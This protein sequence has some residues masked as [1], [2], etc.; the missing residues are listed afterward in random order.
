VKALRLAGQLGEYWL[1]RG[2]FTG[3]RW[4]DAARDAAG[5]RAPIDDRARVELARAVLLNVQFQFSASTD[6]ARSTVDLYRRA[7]DEAGLSEA[8]T[9]L[10]RALWQLGQEDEF[11]ACV[12]AALRHA[13][14][15]GHDDLY[16][17]QLFRFAHSLPA[18]ERLAALERGAERLTLVGNH[19]D[20]ALGYSDAAYWALREDRPTEALTLLKRALP[21]AEQAGAPL[22][23]M[24]VSSN[25]GLTNLFVSHF[26]RALAAFRRTLR[27]CLDHALG[28]RAGEGLAGLAALAATQGRPERAARLLGAARAR[29]YPAAD[30]QV[31]LDRLDRDYL[32]P[33]RARSGID[34]WRRE[35][36]AG[37]M[38]S[39][40]EA[41]AYAL[42]RPAAPDQNEDGVKPAARQSAR[43]ETPSHVGGFRHHRVRKQRRGD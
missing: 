18:D 36:Q 29:G 39:Y 33:A 3:L 32:A 30:D 1:V 5:D 34:A 11:R 17:K 4:L 2:D 10:A 12:E 20:L 9:W 28:D 8:Y 21:A 35:E 27:L 40:D 19:R 37:A 14:L 41:I 25:L 38:L 42:R 22:L 31:I 7:R 24:T 13:R 6:A 43:T 23:T 16:G 26:D 15:T